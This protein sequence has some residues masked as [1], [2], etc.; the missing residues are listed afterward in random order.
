MAASGH[1]PRIV[2]LAD[3]EHAPDMPES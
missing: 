3:R 1:L 2:D